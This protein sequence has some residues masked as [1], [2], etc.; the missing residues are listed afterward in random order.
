M[1]SFTLFHSSCVLFPHLLSQGSADVPALLA[2]ETRAQE[3]TRVMAM[4]VVETSTREAATTRD[5]AALH[6]KDAEDQATLGGGREALE[7]VSRVKA[8]NVMAL[9]SARED[10]EGIARRDHPS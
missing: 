5:S 8:E 9:A 1:A 10:A 4:L 2:E 7:R 3:V 6:G